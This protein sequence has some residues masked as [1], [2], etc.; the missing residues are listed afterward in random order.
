[1]SAEGCKP[2]PSNVEAIRDMKAP[3]KVKEVRRFLGMCGFYR[4]HIPKFA[5]IATPLTNHTKIN[6]PFVWTDKCQEDFEKLKQCLTQAPILVRVDISQPFVVTTDASKTHVGGV[7]SHVQPD[8][9]N[10]AIAYFLKKL[11]PTKVRYSATDKEAHAVVLTCRNFHHYLWGAKF[12]IFTDAQPLSSIF[13]KKTKFPRMNRWIFG[14]KEYNYVE[15]YVQGKDNHA[16]DNLSRPVR[17]IQRPQ[18]PIWLGK[19]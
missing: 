5:K 18:E 1:M 9:T 11:K 16:V 2:D 12:T 7:L 4:K 13:K 19:T 8:G 6:A 10:K 14:M 15:Q 17:V 3:T